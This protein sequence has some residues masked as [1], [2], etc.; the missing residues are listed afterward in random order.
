MAG[1]RIDPDRGQEDGYQFVEA[2][3]GALT[4]GEERRQSDLRDSRPAPSDLTERG[5]LGVSC[6]T[7][8]STHP[9]NPIREPEHH[10]FLPAVGQRYEFHFP[11]EHSLG[12]LLIGLPG[13]EFLQ[14]SCAGIC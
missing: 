5:V 9:Q 3:R 10:L 11:S 2:D 14:E 6:G 13:C 12:R 7:S 4:F 8:L 1:E